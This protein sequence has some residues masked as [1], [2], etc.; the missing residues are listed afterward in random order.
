MSFLTTPDGV[1]LRLSDR[2]S[3]PAVVLVHGWKMSHR[4]WDRTVANLEDRFRVVAYDHRGRGETDKP[5]GRYDFEEL[6]GDLGAVLEQLRLDDVTLV[7]WSMGCTVALEY[8]R[9]GGGHVG[10][11]VLVNG[12]LRLTR[13]DDFPHTMT[14]EELDGYLAALT[15]RW[16]EDE[17]AFTQ[18]A[19]A[20]PAAPLVQWI[21]SIAMQT[22]LEV[23]LKTV[24]AQALLDHRE[25]V[26]ALDIPVL[27]VYGA[28]DPYYPR[29]LADYI[30][31][32]APQGRALVLERSGH[33]PFL[34][35]D[36][37]VFNDAVA[38]FALGT[39]PRDEPVGWPA[40]S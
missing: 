18:A 38:E 23:V 17:Y 15:A 26:A 2:G 6:S 40:A 1:R 34:E 10:R 9:Q 5:S 3:G 22:P 19:F 39:M 8:L 13:T 24:R 14:E 25:V 33:F 31:E 21:Y 37:D 27:A 29:E 35:A 11:L 20:E 12:P 7:G 36:T 32:R 30:A 4:V 28:R 16:P